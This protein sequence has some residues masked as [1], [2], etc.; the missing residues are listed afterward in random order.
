MISSKLSY[1]QLSIFPAQLP[2]RAVQGIKRA[3]ES[4][5]L[6]TGN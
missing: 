2:A 3:W 6:I 5:E 4:K 1:T